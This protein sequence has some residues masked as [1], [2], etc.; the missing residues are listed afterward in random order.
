M[1]KFIFDIVITH[2]L[3]ACDSVT[4]KWYDCGLFIFAPL[5][6]IA[7]KYVTPVSYVMHFSCYPIVVSN[8]ISY[9]VSIMLNLV[10]CCWCS[11]MV[12]CK[13]FQVFLPQVSNDC[14]KF[15]DI[16]SIHVIFRDCLGGPSFSL[17]LFH[18]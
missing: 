9:E 15:T 10:D 14:G 3:V 4:E 12:I 5:V 18:S 2:Y 1:V 7:V 11:D 17:S 8:T 6:E 13:F 16:P